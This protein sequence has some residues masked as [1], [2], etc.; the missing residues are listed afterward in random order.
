MSNIEI[1]PSKL[2]GS[3]DTPPSK[4]ICHRAI[5]AAALSN[6]T[7]HIKP[8][9]PS[10]DILAT[11]NAIESLGASITSVENT[12]SITGKG[13]PILTNPI[14]DCNESGST[15]RFIIPPVLLTGEKAVVT[16]KGRLS[17]RPLEPYV[18]IFN[19]QNI[20]YHMDEDNLPLYIKGKLL[21]G[22]FEVRGDISSQFITGLMFALPLLRED[23]TIDITGELESKGYIDLTIDVL[24]A[25]SIDIINDGYKRFYIPG[26]QAYKPIKYIV[27]SDFSQAAFF[28]VA[29]ALGNNIICR[30]LNIK[31][32]QGDRV[33]LDI[34]QKAGCSISNS[35]EYISVSPSML[36]GLDIDVKNCPDLVPILA[37]LGSLSNGM[38]RIYNA[39]RLRYKESNRLKAI[40]SELS[41]IGAYIKETDDGL[42]INGRPYL[43]GGEVDSW[44]D[45]RIAMA[46]SIASTRCKQPITIRNSQAVKKSYPHFFDDFISLGG[47]VHAY[48]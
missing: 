15:M 16:G 22:S 40:S 20:I 21:P 12:L 32:T 26:N 36:N 13:Y 5:I 45:H 43:D 9:V 7:S 27:E 33:I 4:S 17:K 37:V 11:L 42:L 10:D 41:K 44:N 48:E 24:K 31:S 46:L 23:S 19:R 39:Q 1:K 2:G 28:L 30:G 47:I 35:K 34:L 38:T 29:G 25:F 14:I 3:I 8:I 6:G 18:E